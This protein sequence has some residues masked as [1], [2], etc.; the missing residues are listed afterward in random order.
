MSSTTHGIHHITALSGDP[1][2]N[3]A[4]YTDALGLRLV[5]KTVNF[6]DPGTWHLYFADG[7]GTPGTVLTFFPL[8]SGLP[9]GHSGIGSVTT[10]AF[11][12][13]A[14]SYG[15]W[16]ERLGGLGVAAEEAGE[17][18]GRRVIAF[19]DPD[20]LSLELVFEQSP[21]DT[22]IWKD[23][24]VP[25]EHALTGFHGATIMV[26]RTGPTA[27][28]LTG[29][30]GFGERE[31]DGGRLRLGTGEHSPGSSVELITGENIGYPRMGPGVV[32]HIAFRASGGEEQAEMGDR[33]R[34]RGI[35]VT[36]VRDRS[37]FRSVY[38]HEPG[39]VLFEIATDGPGFTVDESEETLG[40]QLMLPPQ[41]EPQRE[42]IMAALPELETTEYTGPGGT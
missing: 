37:Y 33:L 8:G 23:S 28:L 41:F 3:L 14:D 30:L 21:A 20:G 42:T 9:R 6:D 26:D 10:I 19:R 17:R 36:G 24:P 31:G 5:K 38:F 2:Q 1:S 4:F 35:H 40:A 32:H 16:L 27:D 18:Y 15:Y 13:P 39:G 11:S 29:V 22:K 34:D 25:E 7:V 12:A